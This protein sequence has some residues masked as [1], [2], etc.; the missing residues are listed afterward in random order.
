M[1]DFLYHRNEWKVF[2]NIML[3]YIIV[4]K[5][6]VASET[7]RKQTVALLEYRYKTL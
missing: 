6:S 7:F 3:K 5:F 1:F 2:V 4:I